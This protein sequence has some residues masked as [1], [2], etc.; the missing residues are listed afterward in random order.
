MSQYI[1]SEWRNDNPEEPFIVMG[2][3]D[4]GRYGRN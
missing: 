4:D 3:I 2:Q 1:L